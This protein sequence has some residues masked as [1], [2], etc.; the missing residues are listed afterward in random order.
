M[1]TVDGV[2]VGVEVGRVD[3]VS[4]GVE[5]F[6]CSEVKLLGVFCNAQSLGVNMIMLL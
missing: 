5:M 3:G 6:F 2:S 1:C 4:V